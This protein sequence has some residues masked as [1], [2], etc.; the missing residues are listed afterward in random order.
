MRPLLALCAI[1][2]GL[3]V[4]GCDASVGSGSGTTETL[5]Q[6][7]IGF[8]FS[9]PDAFSRKK[10]DAAFTKGRVRAL[11]AMDGDNLID[12]RQFAPTAIGDPA[13]LKR[14]M[15]VFAARNG[16]APSAV[17]LTKR[18]GLDMATFT[19]GTTVGAT[20]TDNEE[21]IF[22]A[23]GA[24]WQLECQSTTAH[25]DDVRKA[26]DVALDSIKAR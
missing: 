1:A 5:D 21:W 24:T 16:V 22:P 6:K 14:Q 23:G 7:D 20:K 10:A 19:T 2:A 9:Y 11:V 8:T 15:T 12:V 17:R 3:L 26:C 4:A 18:S 13:E 25:A